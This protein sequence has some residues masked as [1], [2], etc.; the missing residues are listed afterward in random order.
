MTAFPAATVS[1]P[2]TGPEHA[3]ARGVDG[4]PA[5][6]TPVLAN[7]P[8][9]PGADPT[10]TRFGD[11]VWRLDPAHP[12]AHA[13]LD[14][15]HWARFPPR[16]T[17][18]FKTFALAA[19]DHPFPAQAPAR[20]HVDRPAVSTIINWI[21]YLRLFAAWTHQRGVARLPDLTGRDLD[22]YR[23][24]VLASAAAAKRKAAL[25]GAVRTLWSYRALLPADCQ[26][27]C[28]PF[29]G[30]TGN[31]LAGRPSADRVNKTPRI[32][33]ATMEAL[34]GWALRMVEDIGPDIVAAWQEHRQLDDGNHPSQA[35]LAGLNPTQ[36]IEWFVRHARST[37]AALPGHAG[38]TPPAV[39]YSHL[40]RMLG[41]KHASG[42]PTWPPRWRKIIA[43]AGLPVASGSHL[44]AI[45]AR[46]DGRPWRDH[47]IT[48]TELPTLLRALSAAAFVTTCYLSGMRPGEALNLHRGC[49]DIDQATGEL[50]VRG[51]PGKGHDREPST[52]TDPEP[53]RPWVV[54]QP[55]HTAITLLES[56]TPPRPARRRPAIRPRPFQSHP[57]LLRSRGHLLAGRPRRRTAGD[58]ARAGRRRLDTP[59]PRRARQRPVRPRIQKA[60]RQHSPVRRTHRQPSPQRR[61]SARPGPTRRP[62]RRGDDMRVATRDRGLSQ[63]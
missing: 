31:H 2:P 39:N 15:I 5:A 40:S 61:A 3:R 4:W 11:Q 10:P 44:G 55:V 57:L 32:A 24:H 52:S 9:R 51:R 35:A 49:A 29:G 27:A 59:A 36:R 46:V 50:L 34:L 41:I 13:D 16:L 14:P 1:A 17:P 45:T 58:A 56:I 6:D 18:A 7:R 63:R 53:D 28:D 33:A 12:D 30:A 62:P 22:A 47:P 26:I 38:T 25:L 23:D 54:V 21:S 43:E 20:T 19:L 60:G 42:A 37:G 8:L 48:T